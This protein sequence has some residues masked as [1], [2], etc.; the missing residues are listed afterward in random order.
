M[1]RSRFDGALATSLHDALLDLQ[2]TS[3]PVDRLL[4]Y[5]HT[6]VD[7]FLCYPTFAPLYAVLSSSLPELKVRK[8]RAVARC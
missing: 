5:Q 1:D 4:D 7:H 6:L 3:V 8:L 2:V